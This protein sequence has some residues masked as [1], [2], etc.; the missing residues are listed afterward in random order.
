MGY[1]ASALRTSVEEVLGPTVGWH[2]TTK[3]W[4]FR[5][6][7]AI[8]LPSLNRLAATIGTDAINFDFGYSGEPN[9]SELT[10]GEPG[11]AGYIEIVGD[12]T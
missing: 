12:F 7:Q 8:T 11:E 10:P 6:N 9:W 2:R 5:T 1:K 3:G 4:R